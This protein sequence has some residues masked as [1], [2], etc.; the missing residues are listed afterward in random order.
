MLKMI[1]ERDKDRILLVRKKKVRLRL[2]AINLASERMTPPMGR[3]Y[4][5]FFIRLGYNLVYVYVVSHT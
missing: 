4:N 2:D 3:A 5:I 1:C